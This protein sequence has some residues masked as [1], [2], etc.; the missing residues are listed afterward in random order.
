[1]ART[2]GVPANA[3]SVYITALILAL[4]ITPLTRVG[5]VWFLLW[6]GIWAMASKYILAIHKQHIFNPVAFAV[7][8]TALTLN[9]T[10][11][12]WVGAEPLLPFVLAGSLLIVRKTRRWDSVLAFSG[13]ALCATLA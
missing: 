10:A 7:A 3:E 6:A 9:Q 11:S 5:D 13:V 2:W 8:L 12:W 4:I 1:F